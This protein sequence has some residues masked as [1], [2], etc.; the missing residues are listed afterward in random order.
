[1]PQKRWEGAGSSGRA[2]SAI[3]NDSLISVVLAAFP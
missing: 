2:N 1:M 3:E